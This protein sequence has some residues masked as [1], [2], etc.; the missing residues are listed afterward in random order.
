[1]VLKPSFLITILLFPLSVLAAGSVWSEPAAGRINVGLIYPEQPD[2]KLQY[3]LSH[4]EAYAEGQ[5]QIV[6]YQAHDQG[7]GQEAD[8]KRMEDDISKGKLECGYILS[9]EGITLIRSPI[10]V[11][12][13]TLGIVLASGLA[14]TLSG[15]L[16]YEVL[17]GFFPEKSRAEIARSI[18]DRADVYASGGPFM[19]IETVWIGAEARTENQASPLIRV[20]HGLTALFVLLISLLN[21]SVLASERKSGFLDRVAVIGYEYLLAAQFLVLLSINLFFFVL[22]GLFGRASG[23]YGLTPVDVTITAAEA[24]MAISFSAAT[25]AAAIALAIRIGDE[26]VY[27]PLIVFLFVITALFGN[28]IFSVEEVFALIKPVPFLLL[29]GFYMSGVEKAVPLP[30]VAA[31]LLLTAAFVGAGMMTLYTKRVR[32]SI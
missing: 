20:F 8:R 28:V 32:G 3:V 7:Q 12:D 6:R 10:T 21:A 30:E 16:G 17:K 15:E 14:E 11:S 26:G 5:V 22:C 4:F 27:T 9:S 18:Q 13:N 1:M 29:T 19:E 31:L 25:A 23:I 24:C 2:P